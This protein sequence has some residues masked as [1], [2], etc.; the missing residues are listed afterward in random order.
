MKKID[1]SQLFVLILFV[2]GAFSCSPQYSAHF[3][4]EPFYK[5][6]KVV[7]V[8]EPEI[9]E[10]TDVVSTSEDVNIDIPVEEPE[11]VVASTD[12]NLIAR[13]SEI[14]SVKKIVEEH[15]ENVRVL[16]ASEADQKVLEKQ[17]RKEEKRAQREVK[18][19]LLK[20]I[21]EVKKADATKAM[22]QKI[23][24]GI[25]I[26]GAGIV[27]AILASGGLGAV[28]IIVGVGLIAWGIIEQGGI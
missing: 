21:K 15:K 7:A 8:P 26:A 2:A 12:K 13:L 20:E 24:I 16:K 25:V 28:A 10:T 14:P 3:S 27:I 19:E 5:E 6:K 1:K 18:K 9:T 22:N 23:F 17:I 11:T 4:N